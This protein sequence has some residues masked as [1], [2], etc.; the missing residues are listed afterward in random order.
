MPKL[1]FRYGVMNASK[2]A[3]L[4][5]TAHNFNAKGKA[6]LVLKSAVDT[7]SPLIQSRT[8]MSRHP[9]VVVH[10]NTNLISFLSSSLDGP[11][12][13]KAIFVDEV[14]FLTP[15]QIDQLREISCRVNVFCYGLRTDFRCTLFP[16]S[17]RLLEV[18]DSIKELRACC[19]YCDRKAVVNAKFLNDTVVRD[20][21]ET[22]DIGGEEKYKSMCWQCWNISS[23]F[24]SLTLFTESFSTNHDLHSD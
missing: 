4:L 16:A 3:D 7:R 6:V 12:R 23:Y 10:E 8:G 15:P 19:E 9:D 20:G 24:P 18:A 21:A 2:T 22:I 14:Q 5:M 11:M 1:Y 17:S 13:V